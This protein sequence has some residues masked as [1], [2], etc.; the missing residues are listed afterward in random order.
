MTSVFF[1][2][3]FGVG[4]TGSDW[5]S[6][7]YRL[8]TV[9]GPS[10]DAAAGNELIGR[11]LEDAL[12]GRREPFLV[13]RVGLGGELSMAVEYF[14][15]RGLVDESLFT[16]AGVY[17]ST[18]LLA[19]EFASRYV[20]A[21]NSSSIVAKFGS[22]RRDEEQFLL[23]RCCEH[24]T[25]VDNRAVEPFYF[26]KPW[27]KHLRG[28]R[29][30]VV[31]PFAETIRNQQHK[32]LFKDETLLPPFEIVLVQSF[33]TIAGAP[34]PHASWLESLEALKNEVDSVAPFDVAL[35]GCG[36]YGL[37]LM[38]HILAEHRRP[39]IY[40]GGA[41]QVLFGIKGRRWA[42][43]PDFATRFFNQEWVWPL[44]ETVPP[45]CDAIE[46]CAYYY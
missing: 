8:G 31:H 13:S 43:R 38:Y 33:Q 32:A 27:S 42:D 10:L 28:R 15:K 35:L 23:E 14:E 18:R 25:V 40:V 5:Y 30:L 29:V 17:P 19:K 12:E 3:L 7:S 26:R 39:A 44:N 46:N 21:L 41:L 4:T 45:G 34:K 6:S 11:W 9:R 24:A 16:H 36:A 37:P 20:L 22:V 2:A 1:W